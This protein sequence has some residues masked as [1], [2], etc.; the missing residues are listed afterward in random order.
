MSKYYFRDGWHAEPIG[1]VWRPFL[2]D[3][4]ATRAVKVFD[5]HYKKLKQSGFF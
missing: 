1:I 2:H 3:S 5:L 4:R